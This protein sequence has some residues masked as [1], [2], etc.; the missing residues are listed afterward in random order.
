MFAWRDAS[1]NVVCGRNLGTSHLDLL[2]C[3]GFS[4]EWRN[5]TF[6]EEATQ[7]I[8]MVVLPLQERRS[9]WALAC[10]LPTVSRVA[11]HYKGEEA[12]V[13]LRRATVAEGEAEHAEV[14][15]HGA[16]LASKGL[17]GRVGGRIGVCKLV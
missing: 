14:H 7:L 8:G 15:I 10:V 6:S 12:R 3:V 16:A 17:R 2:L 13:G 5:K 4:K 1:A 9:S 11:A